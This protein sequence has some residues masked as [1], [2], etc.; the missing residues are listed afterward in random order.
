MWRIESTRNRTHLIRRLSQYSA[1]RTSRYFGIMGPYS[2]R[3]PCA[4]LESASAQPSE[5]TIPF[6]STEKIAQEFL[7][8]ILPLSPQ[9]DK[10]TVP[11]GNPHSTAPAEAGHDS[12]GKLGTSSD[13]ASQITLAP[14]GPPDGLVGF[15]TFRSSMLCS[16]ALE[17]HSESSWT[18]LTGT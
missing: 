14:Y 17:I 2:Y 13:K 16:K 15:V 3:S 6:T 1:T 7:L 10:D 9:T 5:D 8:D 12:L 4:T 11:H 18:N